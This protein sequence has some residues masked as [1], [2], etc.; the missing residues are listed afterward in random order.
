MKILLFILSTLVAQTTTPPPS[1]QPPQTTTPTQTPPSSTPAPQHQPVIEPTAETKA[2]P[3][4]PTEPAPENQPVQTP[5]VKPEEKNPQPNLPAPPDNPSHL[6]PISEIVEEEPVPEVE[7]VVEPEVQDEE[8]TCEESIS[9][10][11][12][13]IIVEAKAAWYY[14]TS[15]RFR[16]IYG[17]GS[18]IYSLEANFQIA[19][20]WYIYSSG[21]FFIA[22]GHS[23]G[24]NTPYDTT[25]WFIPVT[26]GA[27]Y[28]QHFCLCDQDLAWY[29]GV[30]GVGTYMHIHDGDPYLK[31]VTATWGG[32]GNVQLGGMYYL[33]ECFLIDIFG[34]YTANYVPTNGK[35][36]NLSGLSVG[37]GLG[38]T[39]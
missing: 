29:V 12:M 2:P 38:W 20:E 30:G 28:L 11:C 35:T 33:T 27:K 5:P 15:S 31:K 26:V 6:T 22:D 39:F 25:I 8:A 13:D 16:G 18:G 21:S 37:G 19:D 14:P 24:S 7:A 32:G 34:Q 4:A 23:E 17:W 3:Q 10:C 1:P 36:V 9:E